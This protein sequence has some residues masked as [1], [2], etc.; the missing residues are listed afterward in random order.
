MSPG[1][2]L[3]PYVIESLLGLGGMGHVYRARDTRL[4]RLVAIKQL[5]EGFTQF[6]EREARAI[7]ALNHPNICQ[8]YDIGPDYMVL[9]YLDGAQPQ[10]PM[11]VTEV[12]PLA[13]ALADALYTAHQRGVLHR[14]LKPANII[15][16]REGVAKLL[17]FGIAKVSKR[18]T[19]V[20]ETLI[21]TVV[22]TVAYMAPEQA[23]GEALDARSDIFSFGAVLYELLSGAPAFPG[24][25]A[26]DVVSA[27][28]RDDPPPLGVPA[29]L[30]R[31]VERCL[32]KQPEHRFQSM[33]ELK[34]A[35]EESMD[36]QGQA[37]PSIAVLAFANLSADKENEYFADGLSEEIINALAQVPGLKVIARTSAFAFKGRNE[38]VRRIAH[39][40]SVNHVLEGSVRRA[41]D[42]VRVTAQLIAA[43]DGS[44]LW[45][46]R[47][48]RPMTDVFAVQDE[49]ALAITAELKGK[50][51]TGAATARQYQPNLASYDQFLKGRAH[52][53]HF[54]PE[55]WNRAKSYFEQAIALDPQYAAPVAEL[56]LGYFISGMHG[57]QPMRE[58]APL[59]RVQAQR[60]LDLDPSDLRPRFLLGA[61]ALAHDYDWNAAGDHFA[62]SM[63]AP[64][65]SADAR[66]IYGSL[67]LGALGR[68]EE[69]TD[70][71]RRAVE[72]DPLNATWRAIWAAHLIHAGRPEEAIR[73]GLRAVELEPQ[74]FVAHQLLGESYL[75]AGLLAAAIAAFERAHRE[76][77][78]N[79]MPTGLLGGALWMAGDQTRAKVL[80]AEMHSPTPYWGRVWYHLYTGELDEAANWYERVIDQRDPFALVYAASPQLAP[81]RAH[82]RWPAIAQM[83]K[84]PLR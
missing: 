56:G 29:A 68:F 4:D 10:G 13:I 77:P 39:T 60:A 74:Y 45:S 18:S 57:M 8:V 23:R 17:D 47:Y 9:E 44:H 50:L 35:L 14:D 28:L 46:E 36:D 3:G 73:E 19:D 72:Q 55:S 51:A 83:M 16:T 43:A 65:V 37:P 54:T 64:N 84:L 25:G 66:W 69:S 24:R 5:I 76:A 32:A 26:M 81:L 42:R 27:V 2:Q 75:A 6:F 52:L 79:A 15:V 22:G 80:L 7:A 61:I 1:T 30:Q 38:D 31:I 53:I 33:A 34:A 12:V 58:V 70:Q 82:G 40:L 62:A 11:P 20:T 67:Y 59:V 41:G 71:M 48:D 78:W 21:G 49:I 63:T